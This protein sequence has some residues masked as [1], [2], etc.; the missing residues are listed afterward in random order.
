MMR[1]DLWFYQYYSILTA[2]QRVL[3]NYLII[4][5]Q[6]GGTTMVDHYLRK[7]PDVLG[8]LKKEISY[9]DLNYQRGLAWYRSHFPKKSKMGPGMVTGEASPYYI[10]FPLSPQR[11][12]QQLPGVKIIIIL[13]NPIDRA[14][15][16]YHH[17]CRQGRETRSFEDAFHGEQEM[18]SNEEEK[19][20]ADPNTPLYN[21]R[22]FSYFSRGLYFRQLERWLA[23]FDRDQFLILNS[24]QLFNNSEETYHQVTRFLNIS[25]WTPVNFGKKNPGSYQPMK[26]ETRQYLA[27]YYHQPNQRLYEML[28]ADFG[29][30]Q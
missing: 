8:G 11:V 16:H 14:Y 12:H 23:L 19:I 22:H 10:F 26:A 5:V 28:G 13:R 15:S 7:H 24:D 18:I 25:D 17:S 1:I 30:E 2:K 29:W 9:F 3:P 4:G 20:L 6:K 27:N 21:H